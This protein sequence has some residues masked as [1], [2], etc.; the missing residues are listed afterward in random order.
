MDP[1]WNDAVPSWR[2]PKT[3]QTASSGRAAR[4]NEGH[5]RQWATIPHAIGST[6]SG[7]RADKKSTPTTAPRTDSSAMRSSLSTLG[8]AA[9]GLGKFNISALH[10][11]IQQQDENK[12]FSAV[13]QQQCDDFFRRGLCVPEI[14][15]GTMYSTSTSIVKFACISFLSHKRYHAWFRVYSCSFP[16]WYT[17]TTKQGCRAQK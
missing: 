4:A 14:F 12:A 5:L 3:P 10:D 11:V 17:M 16:A 8:L 15:Q 9:I 6:T 2:Q 7:S 13:E 1:D